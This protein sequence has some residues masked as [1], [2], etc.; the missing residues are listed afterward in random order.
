MSG[1]CESRG[2]NMSLALDKIP[3][4]DFV[5][6]EYHSRP[7]QQLV[8]PWRL[9]SDD[10]CEL[11]I[12]YFLDMGIFNVSQ[13]QSTHMTEAIVHHLK[14]AVEIRNAVNKAQRDEKL[15]ARNRHSE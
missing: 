6:R 12:N 14:N 3:I 9:E 15:R 13:A 5:R 1:T 8:E 2:C 11:L 4:A 10:L 7:I